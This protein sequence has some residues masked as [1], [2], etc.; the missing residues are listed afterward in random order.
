M[1]GEYLAFRVPKPGSPEPEREILVKL[2]AAIDQPLPEG[3]AHRSSRESGRADDAARRVKRIGPSRAGL[4]ERLLHDPGARTSQGR[5]LAGK[6]YLCLPDDQKSFLAGTFVASRAAPADRTG[7]ARRR[8]LHQWHG[9]SRRGRSGND[10]DHRLRCGP[11]G[12]VSQIGIAG[13]DIELAASPDGPK[14]TE[15]DD[16]KP[17]VTFL[18]RRRWEE[19]AE[20]IRAQ[21]ADTGPLPHIRDAQEWTGR[22]EVGG[23]R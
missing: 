13:V 17:R 18:D 21:Q 23:R 15:R 7:G 12:T 3:K 16:D 19:C 11:N 6:I 2:R 8:A 9:D 4:P 14:W 10:A 1:E 22:V 5:E 20:P